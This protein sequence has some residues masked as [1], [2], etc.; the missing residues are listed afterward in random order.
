M[1]V[2]IGRNK[3]EISAAEWD[4]FV[5][6]PSESLKPNPPANPAP[7]WLSTSVW[8]T[9]LRA[10]VS[11]FP[12]IVAE[13][14]SG[15]AKKVKAW[16]KY[17]QGFGASGAAGAGAV[18]P[19][20]TAAAAAAGAD[21]NPPPGNWANS[22]TSFQRLLLVKTFRDD[23]LVAGV[24]TF[25]STAQDFGPAYTRPPPFDLAATYADSDSR[26]PIIFV[27]SPGANPMS[28]LLKLATDKSMAEDKFRH[29]SLGQN[30]GKLAA[31][32]MENA[33]KDGDW[34]CL[35]NC[36]L[37]LSW[38]P[39][40]E[41]LLEKAAQED[42]A[43]SSSG[44]AG[45]SGG[46]AADDAYRLWLTSMPTEQFPV[47]ILQN[48]I[49]VTNEPPKGL[50]NN[51]M[52]TFLDI[53]PE[54]Y[55]SCTR[56][57]A[58]KKL[59]FAL[60]FFHAV[61]QER[62]KFGSIGWNVKYE[63][64]N[65]DL[66]V[67]KKTIKMYL[68]E[69]PHIPSS[70]V[71]ALTITGADGTTLAA[72]GGANAAG[73]SIN[74]GPSAGAAAAAGGDFGASEIPWQ[75]LQEIIG[76]INYC[77][78]VTD[79][80]DQRCVRSLLAR[81]FDPGVLKDGYKLSD[82]SVVSTGA[83]Q[84]LKSPVAGSGGAAGEAAAGAGNAYVMPPEGSLA[85]VREYISQLPEDSAETFGLHPNAEITFALKESKA[86]IDSLIAI[87]PRDG[88]GGG[89]G[90]S[91]DVVV[92]EVANGILTRL[93]KPLERVGAH[94]ETFADVA[95]GRNSLGV[96][97]G[98][99]VDRFN[100]LLRV[101]NNSLIELRKALDGIS[102]MSSELDAMYSC[103][104][105]NTVPTGWE[106]VAWPSLKSLSSWVEDVLARH[107]FL[108]SWL[109]DGPPAAY[110]LSGFF[111]P[112]GFMTAV[113]QKYAREHNKAIDTVRFRT[114]VMS[115]GP[116]AI[117][118]APSNAP[119]PAAGAAADTKAAPATASPASSG[120]ASILV[121]RKTMQGVYIYGL[122]LQG[123][124]WDRGLGVLTEARPG[125]L[126]DT[127]PVVW[128]N[129]VSVAE[130]RRPGTYDCPLY[131]TSKRAGELSTTGHSTNFVIDLRTCSSVAASRACASHFANCLC[132]LLLCY[133]AFRI[134][135]SAEQE[136]RS[137]GA[138]R[139]SA[140]SAARLKGPATCHQI[141]ESTSFPSLN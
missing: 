39:T 91:P 26:T 50:A 75:T 15:D 82:A 19:G 43:A 59:L 37:Y 110:W 80:K 9:L 72:G 103:F 137:L 111:F 109:V 135:L 95:D 28:Y 54:E 74:T 83:G 90:R 13:L 68:D 2:Q 65:S 35:Q 36:H 49:K 52:R 69:A 1:A 126:F 40:L 48:S 134:V 141:P 136:A 64:M 20:A 118:H 33:R 125:V 120:G 113:L 4:F 42:A 56:P 123:A 102:V 100:A 114:D 122:F 79:D 23:R 77:G 97:L 6:G 104:L 32:M 67:S 108:L 130:P 139:H 85:A 99:E 16:Q 94:P 27:L 101:M 105:Y 63:W 41:Q 45:G 25:V 119:A 57:R 140:H 86:L 76:E 21:S 47:A 53:T 70:T 46:G 17:V 71:A 10:H 89:A 73:I 138:K 44:G 115:V 38:M 131:K 8:H 24:K 107:K 84:D 11:P 58:Y 18:G 51:V 66:E 78:R 93:P 34:V 29:I 106:R 14:R 22:L 121:D 3:G 31:D 129:P 81:Y 30:Q 92:K 62:R 132:L 61:C 127:F 128:L 12:E 116:E 124:S 55:E 7:E 88:G 98:Q 5:R 133:L 60:A 117:K 87:Q 112:Q 96:F